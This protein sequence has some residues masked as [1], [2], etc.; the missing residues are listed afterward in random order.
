MP[1][2]LYPSK[3]GRALRARGKQRRRRCTNATPIFFPEKE[4]GRRPSKRKAF[5]LAV[6]GLN[7]L[8]ASG[9]RLPAHG[10]AALAL[11][12]DLAYFYHPLL[13]SRWRL[14]CLTDAAHPLR[15]PLCSSCRS[16]Q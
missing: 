10:E 16:T 14:C 11:L 15:V 4:N 3:G 5:R 13:R 6:S 1:S 8:C 12:Y 2:F 7:D 9:M